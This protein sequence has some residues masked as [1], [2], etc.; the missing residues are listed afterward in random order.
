MTDLD[1]ESCNIEAITEAI[2]DGVVKYQDAWKGTI[3]K[4]QNVQIIRW[5]SLC[6]CITVFDLYIYI[7]IFEAFEHDHTLN[8]Q[9]EAVTSER[10]TLKVE[11]ACVKSKL[12]K[13]VDQHKLAYD[14]VA[15]QRDD[16]LVKLHDA[17]SQIRTLT[18][19]NQHYFNVITE[20]GKKSVEITDGIKAQA[21]TYAAEIAVISKERDTLKQAITLLQTENTQYKQLLDAEKQKHAM[22][23]IIKSTTA[24]YAVEIAIISKEHDKLKQ[25]ITLLQTENTQYKQLLDAEKQ[26]HA[27]SLQTENIQQQKLFDVEKQHYMKQ[28]LDASYKIKLINDKYAEEIATINKERNT[29]N[30]TITSLQSENIQYKQTHAQWEIQQHIH[31][32]QFK[33]LESCKQ[34][35]TQERDGAKQQLAIITEQLVTLEA[36]YKKALAQLLN[37]QSQVINIC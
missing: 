27:I 28:I 35:I 22:D 36:E 33:Q 34:Q 24:K 12:I 17:T 19:Q 13:M 37:N 31:F 2:I 29:L 18:A 25:A 7:C 26:K 10:D 30:Q 14:V 23:D 5:S 20:F 16:L 4:A 11:L 3:H 21:A 9:L 15:S 1:T 6:V 8:V 32:A